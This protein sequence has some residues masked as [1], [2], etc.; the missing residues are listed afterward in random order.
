MYC[1][2]TNFLESI[3]IDQ[4]AFE[5]KFCHRSYRKV[6]PKNFLLSCFLC[7]TKSNFSL[8]QWAICLSQLSG[9]IVSHQSL[10]KKLHFNRKDFISELV[11]K[12]CLQN[13]SNVSAQTKGILSKFSRVLIQDSTLVNLPNSHYGYSSGVSSGSSVKAMG[14]I[15]VVFDLVADT[16]INLEKC[17][18]SKNDRSYAKEIVKVLKEGDLLLR[19]LGYF[20]TSV[21]KEIDELGAFY[22][23]KLTGGICLFDVST[24]E[25]IDLV[26]LIKANEKKGIYKFD[27]NVKMSKKEKIPVRVFGYRV[28]PEQAMK[29]RQ[30]QKKADI[31]IAE[32]LNKRSF[33]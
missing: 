12:L 7:F 19:D 33:W 32:F 29:K 6:S 22:I 15:Q 5:T 14:R 24:G 11:K 16:I 23:S 28:T 3:N 9:K 20:V 1:K 4:I 10:D 27:L 8:R 26:K 31:R 17:T 30:Q 2:V 13:L 21:F 18:Y 25:E